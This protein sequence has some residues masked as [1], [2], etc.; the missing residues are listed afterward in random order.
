MKNLMVVGIVF[1]LSAVSGMALSPT[2]IAGTWKGDRAVGDVVFL[3]NGEGY[4]VFEANQNLTMHLTY[5]LKSDT[6]EITQ[7]EKN[8]KDFYLSFNPFYSKNLQL[9]DAN[10]TILMD[11]ARPYVWSFTLSKDGKTLT[12]RKKTTSFTKDSMGVFSYDNTYERDAT[13]TRLKGRLDSPTLNVTGEAEKTVV[14]SHSE[15]GVSFFYTTDGTPPIANQS[16]LY[17]APLTFKKPVQVQAVASKP[18][19]MTSNTA[20]VDV[21]FEEPK[22]VPAPTPAAAPALES[23]AAP[24]P[25]PA[26]VAVPASSKKATPAGQLGFYED[27][28]EFA[29]GDLPSGWFGI[30][31]FMVKKIEKKSYLVPMTD[32]GYSGAKI[33]TPRINYY[34]DYRVEIEMYAQAWMNGTTISIGCEQ[35]NFGLN[36]CDRFPGQTLVA[37][38]NSFISGTQGP[39]VSFPHTGIVNMT[40]EKK[41][42]VVSFFFNGQKI[43]FTR[44]TPS[45][46]SGGIQ[47]SVGGSNAFNSFYLKK[48]AVTEL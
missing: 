11:N 10:A 17:K 42:N 26:P 48:I 36:Y 8:R 45:E 39:G 33:T 35:F 34:Q 24:L 14:L 22:P 15:P 41:G 28:T 47:I 16:P 27:F 46:H 44:I 6:F 2:D 7:A 25:A 12:G 21:A 29:D 23:A 4:L 9:T 19:F 13:W 43:Y 30:D 32:I 38:H 3:E 20:R 1:L 31:Q 5:S 40:A 37:A 18:G